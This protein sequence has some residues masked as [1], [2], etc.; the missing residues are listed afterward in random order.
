MSNE[1]NLYVAYYTLNTY[2]YAQNKFYFE[3]DVKTK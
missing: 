1:Y 2:F 3:N